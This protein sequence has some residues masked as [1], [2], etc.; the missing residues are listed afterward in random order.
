MNDFLA[1]VAER[2]RIWEQRQAGSPQ[3]WTDDPIL[4]TYL[5]AH[6]AVIRVFG[7]AKRYACVICGTQAAQW[8]YNHQDKDERVGS[9]AYPFTYSFDV[10]YYQ[11]MCVPCHRKLDYAEN[12]VVKGVRA[13]QLAEVR[14]TQAFKGGTSRAMT[15]LNQQRRKCA[16]CGLVSLP[17]GLGKHLKAQKHEGWVPA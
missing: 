15:R 6:K 2:Y 12:P 10:L 16:T 14:S 11:P 4:A 8:A 5:G 1:F 3:P 17:G 7:A 9:G 13:A